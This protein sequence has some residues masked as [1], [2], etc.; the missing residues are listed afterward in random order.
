MSKVAEDL[1][2]IAGGAPAKQT[3][4]GTQTRYGEEELEELRQALEQGSLFREHGQKV[5]QLEAQFAEK[6]GVPYAVAV[7]SGTAS[8]HVA[9]TALGISPGDEVILSPITDMGSVVPVLFQGAIPVFADLDQD[10]HTLLPES[11]EAN[12][13]PKTRA[14]LAVHLWGNACDLNALR[15]ICQKHKL[16]LIEDCA[17]AFGCTYEGKPIGTIGVIGC[18][19]LN[20]FKHISCGDGGIAITR[21]EELAKRLKLSADK[22]YNREAGAAIRNPKFLA[23]NYRITELQGAVALAQL[24]KLDGIVARRRAYAQGLTEALSGVEGISLPKPTPGCEP[25]WWFYMIRVQPDVLGVDADEFAKALSLEGVPAGAHYIGQPIYEYPI[26][27]NHSAFERGSHPYVE[28]TY[29]RG[30]CPNAEQIL[31]TCVILR[32]NEAFTETDMRETA[33]AVRRVAKWFAEHKGR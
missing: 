3:P 17:Q 15:G 6:N 33:H 4:Y 23:A 31:L 14:V 29:A 19:S 9:M 2:A 20:E 1:P 5:R 28:R 10:T 12:V 11:V 32:V 7:S 26:F 16:H 30:L 24:R 22:C 25:S 21:D 8:I 27:A 18:F 13:T